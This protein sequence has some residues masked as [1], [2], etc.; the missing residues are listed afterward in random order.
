[1][2]LDPPKFW[3]KNLEPDTVLEI[4]T[5]NTIYSV[6]II[7]PDNSTVLISGHEKYCPEPTKARINGCTWGGSMIRVGCVDENMYL[8]IYLYEQDKNI[9]TSLVESAEIVSK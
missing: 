5:R 3:I 2:T 6:R 8:E 7:D 4:Q 9:N 1:M